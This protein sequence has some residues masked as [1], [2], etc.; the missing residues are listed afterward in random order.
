MKYECESSIYW[1]YDSIL[2]IIEYGNLKWK[3]VGLDD[4]PEP[5]WKYSN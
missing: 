1:E 2:G 3:L 5:E 4:S